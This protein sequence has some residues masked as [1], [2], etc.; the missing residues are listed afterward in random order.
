MQKYINRL[1]LIGLC[2]QV[3]LSFAQEAVIYDFEDEPNIVTTKGVWGKAWDLSDVYPRLALEKPNPLK[4]SSKFTVMLWVKSELQ[5]REAYAILSETSQIQFPDKGW[6]YR[7]M[8]GKPKNAILYQGWK[9][10][11]QENGAW[12][13]EAA[14]EA[15]RYVYRPTVA[16]QSIRDGAWHLIGFSYDQTKSELRMYYDGK[17]MAIYYAPA[18]NTMQRAETLVL[19]NSADSEHNYKTKPRDSFYGQMDHIQ[20]YERI[21]NREDVQSLYTE[22]GKSLSKD[23][24][25]QRAEQIGH[26]DSLKVTTFNIFHAGKERG[27]EVGLTRIIDSLK[28]EDSDVYALVETYGSGAKIADALGY[29]LYLISSN[30]SIISR[31]P[32]TQ[33]REVFK[34]FNSGA[35]EIKLSEKQK[36]RIVAVWLHHLP[37]YKAPFFKDNNQDVEAFLKA[38]QK[39]RGNQAEHILADIQPWLEESDAIPVII[40]G[41]FNSGSHLD[42]TEKFSHIHNGYTVAFRASTHMAAVGMVDAFR[43]THTM[44]EALGLTFSTWDGEI[45]YLRDRIDYIYFK[46]NKLE[47]KGSD[48]LDKTSRPGFP[49]DHA[50]VSA[51]FKWSER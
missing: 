39:S 38:D 29:E 20:L 6:K 46:G 12:Y 17:L 48:V 27:R 33:T 22:F 21:L 4:A 10:G 51:V 40:A 23:S 41:D 1:I 36:L 7:I 37:S 24:K 43:K 13:L 35:A 8:K 30:L 32:I 50:G 26:K 9:I 49:S 2:L 42:W 47:V 14:S 25:L 31:Y 34:S 19:G 28:K 44:D 45:D 15:F 11:V 16:R 18:L 3:S 5:S